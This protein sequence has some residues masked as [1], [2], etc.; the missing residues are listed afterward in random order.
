MVHLRRPFAFLPLALLF[1]LPCAIAHKQL[2]EK[3]EAERAVHLLNRLTFGPRPGDQERVLA[4]GLDRW[5]AQQLHPES[6]DDHALEVRL[7][8]FRT[9][10]MNSRE[11]A[12][13][14][15]P[16]VVI[17]QVAE[18]KLGLPRDPEKRAIYQAQLVRYRERQEKKAGGLDQGEMAVP[19]GDASSSEQQTRLLTLAP[20]TRVRTLLRMTP[21]EQVSFLS[22][23][24]GGEREL[25]VEGMT[26][27]Q[28]ETITAINNPQQVVND[29]LMA[30]KIL[31]ATYSER[32]LEE[33]MTD[34]WLNHFNVFI[35]KGADRYEISSYEHDVIRPHSLGKFEDLLV[36]TAES[37]AMLFYLDNWLSVGS[38][39]EFAS[40]VPRRA[41]GRRYPG[42]PAANLQTK[43]RNGLNENYGRELMELHTLGVN[44]GYTQRDVTEVAK[45][46]TG[47]TLKQP[48]E[49]GGFSFEE[50]MHE[51]G[52]KVVLG[53][54]IKQNGQKE[55]YQV[56]HLLAHHP[57]TAKFIATKLAMRFVSD[58]PPPALVERMANTFLKK[59][60]DIRAVLMTMLASPEFWA[61]ETYRAK[62]KTPLEF[63][64]SALRATQA[65]VTDAGE[66]VRQLQAL[67][68]PLY[69]AQPPTGYSMKAEA[70]VNSS[71][72]L[73]RMNFAIRLASARIR[74]VEMTQ[75]VQAP[76]Q[77]RWDA[78]QALR[79][80]EKILL[81]GNVS[82]E[83]HQ[84]ISARLDDPAVTHRRLDDPARP[85]DFALIEG[86]LLGS[87]EFQRR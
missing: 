33:V 34:F 70:W 15:P 1:C 35:G 68:M 46:F 11:L 85:P 54:R 24:R 87:P 50:R 28:R 80:L 48:R 2:V 21:E 60:G 43:R 26:P 37:P 4:I 51:P 18:G 86:L 41:G 57:S 31:R 17:R 30:A 10:R 79:S 58:S 66:I 72:L 12:E 73:G 22:G 56:L 65:E 62:V 32:Q 45:V 40:G 38:N 82:A 5:I 9:L 19:A 83:T 71:A 6:I 74:G 3:N 77:E 49:G 27:E 25:L 42:A 13:N 76:G 23:L 63:M 78:Q 64:V 8:P 52:D 81:S 47:W 39:S 59:D 84:T 36:R 7:A 53:H 67:G 16:H 20:E 44:G 61:P 69:G 55:G 14:F 29:E 75:S